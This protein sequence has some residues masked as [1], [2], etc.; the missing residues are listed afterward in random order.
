MSD[1][2]R[3]NTR[4]FANNS[5]A[6]QTRAQTQRIVNP[7]TQGN[8]NI[9]GSSGN[10][11]LIGGYGN[12]T[13]EGGA[14]ADT[15]GG[16][17]G[18]DTIAGGVDNDSLYGGNG[19]DS[20]V[21][22]IGKDRLDG[23][24][25][26]DTLDGGTGDDELYGGFGNDRL[27]GSTGNDTLYG[28]NGK[29]TLEGGSGNDI[30]VVDTKNDVVTEKADEGGDDIV[31]AEVDYNLGDHVEHLVLTGTANLKGTGNSLGNAM[32][33]NSGDNQLSGLGGDDSFAASGGSDS[34]DGG[35]GHDVYT[36]SPDTGLPEIDAT[37]KSSAHI[38]AT[39]D[40][41]GSGTV[42]KFGGNSAQIGTDTVSGIEEF[43]GSEN[44]TNDEFSYDGAITDRLLVNGIDD[45]ATGT[46]TPNGGG[47]PIEF[48]GSSG[49]TFSELLKGDK[50]GEVAGT[51]TI[52]AGDKSGQIG[53]ISFKEFETI[54]FE[55]ATIENDIVQ[56]TS[57]N[58]TIDAAYDGDPDDDYVDT[59][60]NDTAIN[61]IIHAYAGNDLV[62]AGLGNDSVDGGLG[63][64][65]LSGRTG[66]DS[67]YGGQGN[68]SLV[69]D[70]GQDHLYGGDGN[71][72]LIGGAGK[73][74]LKGGDGNDTYVVDS[75][76][77]DKV[78]DSSGTDEIQSSVQYTL[79]DASGVEN[80]TLTGT[81]N[82]WGTGNVKAN[83]ITG[84]DGN[85][86]LKGLKGTD[87][88]AGGK[89]DDSLEGGDGTD[90]LVGGA[91]NDLMSGGNGMDTFAEVAGDGSDTISDFKEADADGKGGDFIDLSAFY[92][93]DT[94]AAVNK[95]GGTFSDARAM[96][97]KDQEDGHLDGIIGGD[98]YSDQIGEVDLYLNSGV[99]AQGNAVA[100]KGDDLTYKNTAVVCFAKGTLLRTVTG[101]KPV[102]Q[103]TS[104]D[105]VWTQDA[106]YQ[107]VRWIGSRYLSAQDLE[108][109]P[110]LMPVRIRAGA[111]GCGLPKRDLVVSPQH[112]MLVQAQLSDSSAQE[113][114]IL[115]G[116]K[117]LTQIEGIEVE[118][119]GRDVTYF[120]MLF[121]CHQVVEAEGALS[122]SLFTGQEAL[123]SLS[124]AARMEI[125]VLF[126]ELFQPDLYHRPEPA[127]PLT[128]GAEGREIAERHSNE[129]TPLVARDHRLPQPHRN[130]A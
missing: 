26:N 14:G 66:D 124:P 60:G 29:D 21:G 49:V 10:D 77:D 85:N 81:N 109:H 7:G 108:D 34:I 20:L 120:H 110:K 39:I 70:G 90:S 8:D 96:M 18:D 43:I 112:R 122:E 127:R 83:V 101:D 86:M 53:D 19:D 111:L 100:V 51:F 17:D 9:S 69:G 56:G 94:L 80:L 3:E 48:G 91:G 1:I 31:V 63:N 119:N 95:A 52:T 78:T 54:T 50:N 64:D 93:K 72:L 25:G 42:A 99:D 121:D 125:A 68:D 118:P 23:G 117:F 33:G 55:V 57:G 28:G 36:N 12:D 45:N 46:F 44:N 67:L 37:L 47:T 65:T 88:L 6:E 130:R 98:N 103:V 24:N 38:K 13:L 116:A 113:T 32:A 62:N 2:E 129:N 58:D 126:P 27:D 97:Q 59:K 35:G 82:S 84:N 40:S 73:D 123:K 61:D 89:G 5:D 75:S 16:G 102:E 114:E 106:G 76:T 74:T 79:L 41:T 71:D 4:S 15:I 87:T 11:T 128:T 92:N 22:G 30:Y 105:L 115:I 107:P 104:G